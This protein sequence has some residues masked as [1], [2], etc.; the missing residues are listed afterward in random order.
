MEVTPIVVLENERQCDHHNDGRD[1]LPSGAIF[2]SQ[3]ALVPS[4]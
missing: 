3:E 2:A 1:G 4:Q